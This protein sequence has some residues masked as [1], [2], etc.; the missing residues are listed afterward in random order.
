MRNILSYLL[1]KFTFEIT[2]LWAEDI[3]DIKPPLDISVSHHFWWIILG[4]VAIIG[5]FNFFFYLRKKEKF[6]SDEPVVKTPFERAYEQLNQLKSRGLPL[7]GEFKI[8]YTILSDIVRKYIE[9][10]FHI[11]APEMTTEEFLCSLKK[12]VTLQ[13]GQRLSL[14]KFLSSC[15]LVKFARY[16]PRPLEAEESFHLAKSFI[17][18]TAR[19]RSSVKANVD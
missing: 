5:L 9:D 15:D 10:Q 13:E 19:E 18:E 14:E 4:V 8:F 7:K 11:K 16:A 3:R 2:Q 12:S 6:L 1:L 17:D